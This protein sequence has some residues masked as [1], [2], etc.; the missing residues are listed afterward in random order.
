M[1]VSGSNKKI[2]GKFV[3]NSY[4]ACLFRGYLKKTSIEVRVMFAIV[5]IGGQQFEVQDN[6][7]IKAP[8]LTGN[9]GD[10]VT[11]DKV[12]FAGEGTDVKIGTPTISGSV[13][14]KI[15]SH[16]KDPKVLVFHKKRRKGYRKLN[17]SR[18]HFT[19]IEVTGIKIA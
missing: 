7:V 18:A 19:K 12:Y 3:K 1:H 2:F 9:P 16:G 6:A 11:F 17:T 13:T 8:L 14:A 5:E 10:T 15:L 4:I